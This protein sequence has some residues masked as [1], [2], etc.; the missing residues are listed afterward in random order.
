[1]TQ[2]GEKVVIRLLDSKRAHVTMEQLGLT[3][4]NKHAFQ[5]MLSRAQGMVLVT[6]STGSGK[7]STLYT[8]LNWVK[9]PA[10]NIITVEDPVEY[11]L[12]GVNQVQINT[13]AD[14]TFAAGLRSILRQDPNIILVGEIRDRETAGIALEAA[15]TGHLLLS[16]LHTND[17]PGAITRL[18]DLGIEPFL[19]SSAVIGILAQRLVRRPCPSCQV[20]KPADAEVI[21]KAGGA[22]R[23]PAGANWIEARGCDECRQTGYT[24]R[25]A[26]H[27]LLTVNDE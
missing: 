3:P 7:T 23:L 24:G 21:E 12:E 14:V 26:I 20:S 25:I 16:T 8:A 18:F 6:G 2:F 27:E 1:P 11:Q 22:S 17:A 13:K 10:K 4:D 19:I 5:L 15:Q 9:S